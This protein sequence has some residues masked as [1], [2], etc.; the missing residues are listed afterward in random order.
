[1]Y[2]CRGKKYFC[3]YER[4]ENEGRLYLLSRQATKLVGEG[5]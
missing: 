2:L 5:E 1:M 3:C 4:K